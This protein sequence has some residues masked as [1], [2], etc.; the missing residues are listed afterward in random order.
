[1]P[2][3]S[4]S[5]GM[6]ATFSIGDG[7]DGGSTTFVKVGE[8]TNITPPALTRE[9]TDATHLESPDDA[10][11]YIPGLLDGEPSTVVF[12]YIP[13]AADPLYEAMKAGKGDFR[14]TYPGGV[15]LNFSGIAQSWKPGE[16]STDKMTGEFTVKPSGLP[17]L[18]AGA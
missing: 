12:N 14:I 11:E 15:Q 13:G 2:V 17:T 18:A 7:A 5:N 8:V 10:R 6:G 4:A 3:T 1:M 16:P 9:A